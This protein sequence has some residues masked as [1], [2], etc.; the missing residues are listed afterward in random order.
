MS[1]DER[2]ELQSDPRRAAR[3][4]FMK[5]VGV[6]GALIAAAGGAATAGALPAA[7]ADPA[8]RQAALPTSD[9]L[10]SFLMSVEYVGAQLYRLAG[11]HSGLDPAVATMLTQFGNHHQDHGD[12][13]AKAVTAKESEQV[14][15]ARL[16][17]ERS[18]SVTAAADQKAVLTALAAFEETIAA[19]Y[20]SLVGAT[21]DRTDARN[22]GNVL[23]VEVQHAV[24]I[25]D[26]LKQSSTITVPDREPQN[27]P[28]DP[29]AYAPVSAT[30]TASAPA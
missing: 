12:A 8:R 1:T 21:A 7:F 14:P 23:A 19:T 18:R 16:L 6:G 15:N 13:W 5:Q 20:L 28:L 17:S 24:A 4:G 3:R 9:M 11:A 25:G 29:V 26:R 30:T 2:D 22:Y 27:G 10:A